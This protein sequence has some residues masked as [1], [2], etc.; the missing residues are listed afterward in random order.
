[1][2]VV[3]I[4][5]SIRKATVA[6]HGA[7]L[8]AW[9]SLASILRRAQRR[10]AGR[11]A[12]AVD[13]A[14]DPTVSLESLGF[15]LPDYTQP[16]SNIPCKPVRLRSSPT[17]AA[18]DQNEC[19]PQEAERGPGAARG[20]GRAG[21]AFDGSYPSRQPSGPDVLGTAADGAQ[22]AAVGPPSS[23][24]LPDAVR[25]TCGQG[26]S[27]AQPC[28]ELARGRTADGPILGQ[29]TSELDVVDISSLTH[30]SSLSLDY[31]A[32]RQVVEQG[33]EDLDILC[34][35][36]DNAAQEAA[37]VSVKAELDE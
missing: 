16:G 4:G 32:I 33:G 13:C 22:P 31:H 26:E 17:P 15:V 19:K 12:Q 34:S 28:H 24:P 1:M 7:A 9:R 18:G 20:E 36:V 37:A 3:T 8:R 14:P 10:Q 27:S 2:K 25:E 29:L 6:G 21:A 35:N 5:E 11:L 30:L 23:E